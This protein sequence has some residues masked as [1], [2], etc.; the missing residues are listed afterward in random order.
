MTVSPVIQTVPWGSHV[1]ATHVVPAKGNVSALPALLR[2]VMN[3]CIWRNKGQN[4]NSG[5]LPTLT[6]LISPP[7]LSLLENASLSAH[8]LC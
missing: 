4:L 2:V 1:F 8:T 6:F 3:M 5:F 7:L